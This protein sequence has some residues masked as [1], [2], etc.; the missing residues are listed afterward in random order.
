MGYSVTI[1]PVDVAAELQMLKE[2]DHKNFEADLI[3]FEDW[4]WLY[5]V[6]VLKAVHG[7]QMLGVVSW[8][9]ENMSGSLSGNTS[10]GYISNVSVIRSHRNMGI[11]KRLLRHCMANMASEGIQN[12]HLH[13]FCD[14]QAAIKLYSNLGFSNQEYIRD[15]HNG[16]DAYLMTTNTVVT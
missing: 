11:G 1:V 5:S 3:R 2:L 8:F 10:W 12:Y 6:E 4:Q 14:N 15:Y 16:K 7:A 9:K 13:V